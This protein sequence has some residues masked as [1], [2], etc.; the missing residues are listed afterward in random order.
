MPATSTQVLTTETFSALFG[1]VPGITVSM[2]YHTTGNT[3][4]RNEMQL[5]S[6]MLDA[7]LKD[8][9]FEQWEH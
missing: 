3:P 9:P 2:T 6:D 4:D 8:L 5:G 7:L 1:K